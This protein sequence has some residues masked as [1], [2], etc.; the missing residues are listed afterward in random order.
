M[1]QICSVTVI[2]EFG[3]KQLHPKIPGMDRDTPL[4]P[5]RRHLP[6]L[7]GIAKRPKLGPTTGRHSPHFNA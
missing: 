2:P 1:L 7:P 3:D 6:Q 4:R 5:M